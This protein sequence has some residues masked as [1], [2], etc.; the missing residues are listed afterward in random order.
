MA[1]I[2]LVVVTPETTTVDAEVDSIMVPLIDGL[3][4]ILPGHAPM[5]GRLGPGEL[6][7]VTGSASERY[8]VDGGFVQV[9]NN[10]VSVLTGRSVPVAEIDVAAAEAALKE[11]QEQEAGNADLMELK[12]KAIAQARAQIRMVKGE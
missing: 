5:I 9:E 3:A 6:R 1:Q 11:A 7:T 10:K 12:N 2:N 4:G 8:Y